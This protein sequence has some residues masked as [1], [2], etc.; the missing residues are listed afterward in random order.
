MN[1]SKAAWPDGI[2]SDSKASGG[3][4]GG[5]LHPGVSWEEIK[6]RQLL[7]SE[8]AIHFDGTPWKRHARHLVDHLKTNNL[9]VMA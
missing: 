1:A 9:L 4:L 2:L 5:I 3:V 8:P 7:A 6:P